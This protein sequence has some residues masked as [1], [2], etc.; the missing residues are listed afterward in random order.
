M[1]YVISTLGEDIVGEKMLMKMIMLLNKNDFS[2]FDS[3]VKIWLEN[4]SLSVADLAQCFVAGAAG[5]YST[6]SCFYKLIFEEWILADLRHWLAESPQ[7]QTSLGTTICP[8]L[9][10]LT[11]NHI[12]AKQGI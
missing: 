1:W 11:G 5:G 12:A 7:T 3:Q 10:D 6:F 8:V 4:Y 2:G 9:L